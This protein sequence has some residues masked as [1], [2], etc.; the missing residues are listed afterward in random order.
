[1]SS[2]FQM[3]SVVM[4][5]C[6]AIAPR[7]RRHRN[8]H[9]AD[10]LSRHFC[11]QSDPRYPEP[12]RPASVPPSRLSVVDALQN[13]ASMPGSRGPSTISPATVPT[14]ARFDYFP[15][16]PFRARRAKC[17]IDG[18]YLPGCMAALPRILRR[19][20]VGCVLKP[21]SSLISKN[22]ESITGTRRRPRG[23]TERCGHIR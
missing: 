3:L 19:R 9:N 13:A 22:G 10:R 6:V 8:P 5:H 23:S 16:Q 20:R 18:R 21:T 4:V 11:Q 7:H 2:V 12:G 1:V 17:G 14:P 15:A